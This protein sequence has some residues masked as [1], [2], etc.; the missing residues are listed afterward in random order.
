MNSSAPTFLWHD[1][2]TFGLDMRIDRP[3]QFAAVRT[4]LALQPVAEP[5]VLHCRLSDDCLPQPR[6][7][8]ITGITPQRCDELGVDEARFARALQSELASANSCIVGYNNLRFDDGFTRHLFYRNF[9]DPYAHEWQQGNSRWDLIDLVRMTYALRP[10]GIDWPLHEDGTPSFRLEDLTRANQI[11]HADAHD[12]LA[13]VEATLAVA[14][15]IKA[16]QPRLFDYSYRMRDKREVAR[17]I[18]LRQP[19]PVLHVSG[20]FPAAHGHTAIVL[21]LARHAT[22]ANAVICFDLSEDPAP[23]LE[24]SVEEIRQR[25]FSSRE[26]LEQQGQRRIPLKLIHLNRCPAI[27]PL[28]LLTPQLAERL[29]IDRARCERHWQNFP[30]VAA[31]TDKLQQIFGEPPA[32]GEPDVEQ[33][34]YTGSFWSEPDR[35]LMQQLQQEEPTRLASY[36]GRF[37]DPRL[38]EL[39]FR[40]RARN[41][42]HTLSESEQTRW[43]QWR[44]QRLLEGG[45][46]L[47][48]L[49]QFFAQID[50]LAV[51]GEIRSERDRAVLV[52]LR[53]HGERLARMV[54]AA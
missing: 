34:L 52:Q 1:Y 38:P 6:S 17:L 19:T 10:D 47:L 15:L 24:C 53:Q 35:R 33:A 49:A 40:Y 13:D 11:A 50:Q 14:R 54:E 30:A 16:R 23:L 28:K 51:S 20:R 44:R 25:L 3:A 12:A 46:G 18:D 2:E 45:P 26:Q 31:L 48:T 7:C 29:Q 36:A 37:A 41:H 43:Q 27:A 4:D 32:Q 8:L 9:L 42:P 5:V 39:L 22:N 21:P